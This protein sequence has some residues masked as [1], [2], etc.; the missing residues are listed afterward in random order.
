MG[1]NPGVNAQHGS[2]PIVVEGWQL[3]GESLAWANP[4]LCNYEDSIPAVKM[5]SMGQSFVL[6][7]LQR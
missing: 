3:R 2:I 7:A 5:S 1:G 4:N 6:Q